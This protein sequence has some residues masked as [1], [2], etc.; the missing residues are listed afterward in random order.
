MSVADRVAAAFAERLGLD[1][2]QVMGG[3]QA[4]AEDFRG[5][6]AAIEAINPHLPVI[7]QNLETLRQH[8]VNHAGQ[9][10][11]LEAAVARLEGLLLALGDQVRDSA[12]ERERT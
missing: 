1:P 2:K 11:R 7:H 5:M 6:R 8:G 12:R 3:F 10:A 4:M 9:I